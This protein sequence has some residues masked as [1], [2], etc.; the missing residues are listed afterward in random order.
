MNEQKLDIR[1]GT[2]TFWIKK[3][4]IN[5]N[6]GKATVLLNPSTNEG[7]ISLVKDADNV[8]KFSHVITGQGSTHLE[9]DVSSLSS[10]EAHMFALT[11]S[12][13]TKEINL[14]IDGEPVAKTQIQY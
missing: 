5:Y 7:S 11:W 8:V 2:I 9:Y 1:E 3:G 14:Y 13:K 4:T 6:D 10:E 12:I